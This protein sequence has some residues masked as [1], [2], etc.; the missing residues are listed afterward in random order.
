MTV[1]S[2]IS[3]VLEYLI[4][5]DEDKAKE[6]FHQVVIEKARAI[7]EELM[8]ADEEDD[9]DMTHLKSGTQEEDAA[10][11][12][13]PDPE[14]EDDMDMTHLNF[15][16]GQVEETETPVG[17][18]GGS[19]NQGEDVTDDIKAMEDEIDFEETMDEADA[20]S[21]EA[22]EMDDHAVK[23]HDSMNAIDDKMQ[24]LETALAELKAEF[25]KLEAEEAGEEHDEE[26]EEDEEGEMEMEEEYSEDDLTWNP[27]DFQ[28]DIIE[29]DEDFDDLAESLELEIVEKDPLKGNKSAGEVG[30]GHSGM[31]IESKPTSPLPKSQTTRYGAKP[32][33]TGKGPTH[34]GYNLESAPKSADL[35]VGDNRRKKSTQGSAPMNTGTYGAKK[36]SNSKLE[37]TASEFHT[38]SNKMSPL[39][40]GGDN[41][42]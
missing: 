25:E 12:L 2:K 30:S 23:A 38:D 27:S 34:S 8:T 39:S 29:V 11:T 36:V 22:P 33:E 19:G 4:K 6:I 21:D 18:V 42:K 26:G 37:T 20:D 3:Q 16:G 5:N 15:G 35:G 28:T 40:K 14:D 24:D 10:S 13:A 1:N 7:H 17:T 32:I 9:E 41:L 31:S